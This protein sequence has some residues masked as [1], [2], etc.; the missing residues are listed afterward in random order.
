MG[1]LPVSGILRLESY[2]LN[3]AGLPREMR[4]RSIFHCGHR[5]RQR[6]EA[7]GSGLR[8]RQKERQGEGAMERRGERVK[9]TGRWSDR[10]KER[11]KR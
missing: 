5:A 2:R 7:K 4:R 3:G 9:M 1:A 8:A 6:E 10:E 11:K